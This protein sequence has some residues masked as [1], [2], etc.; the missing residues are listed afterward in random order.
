MHELAITESMVEAI[1][2]KVGDGAVDVVRLEI[3]R[4][5]G[6][7]SDSVRF[8]FEIVAAGTGLEGARLDI[9]EPPGR[10]YCRECGEE[11]A[12]DE[13]I[14]LCPCGSAN[15]DILSGRQLRIIS[16]EVR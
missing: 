9:D 11:F 16:V 6:L 1:V 3:G 8:C 2:A 15:L 13:P 4:L 12:L 10:A 5:S 7:V 14:M